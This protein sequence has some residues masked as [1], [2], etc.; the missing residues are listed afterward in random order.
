MLKFA[1]LNPDD[2]RAFLEGVVGEDML[3]G[4]NSDPAVKA[5]GIQVNPIMVEVD[6]PGY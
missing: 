6:E 1:G 4:F 5:F 3:G 2:R